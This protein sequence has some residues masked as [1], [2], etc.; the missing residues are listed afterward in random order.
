MLQHCQYEQLRQPKRNGFTIHGQACETSCTPRPSL[1]LSC[2]L[3]VYIIQIN[4]LCFLWQCRVLL[5]LRLCVSVALVR[6]VRPERTI[7]SE[8]K[9]CRK[10][11]GSD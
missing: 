11:D 9:W 1:P 2:Q 4:I 3:H 6:F 10:T 7:P 5:S 8:E